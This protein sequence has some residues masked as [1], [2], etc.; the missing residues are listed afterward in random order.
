[1]ID[2]ALKVPTDNVDAEQI[3]VLKTYCANQVKKL[4]TQGKALV[5]RLENSF[6]VVDLLDKG[7]QVISSIYLTNINSD[8]KFILFTIKFKSEVYKEK[9]NTL[10]VDRGRDILNRVERLKLDNKI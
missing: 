9:F 6:N 1:M 3:K 8:S 7:D 5:K 2:N 10:A 4:N